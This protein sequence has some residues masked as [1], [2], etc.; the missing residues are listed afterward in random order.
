MFN[1]TLSSSFRCS[2]YESACMKGLGL[3]IRT[4]R[5]PIAVR[6]RNSLQAKNLHDLSTNLNNRLG[7][8]RNEARVEMFGA[9]VEDKTKS[10]LAQDGGCAFSKGSVEFAELRSLREFG[11]SIHR[12][13]LFQCVT[14][15]S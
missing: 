12:F 8:S 7:L 1:S 10:Q 4:S 14:F 5:S 3:R 2:M 9:R 6:I 15:Y 11:L 13:A